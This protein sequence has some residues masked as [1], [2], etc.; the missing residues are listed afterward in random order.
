[1]NKKYDVFISYA[2]QDLVVAREIKKNLE[3]SGIRCWKAPDSIMAGE[4]WADAI[5][6]AIENTNIM[7]IVWS[8]YFSASQETSKEL[9]LASQH[10]VKIVPFRIEDLQPSGKW[11]YQLANTHWMNAHDGNIELHVDELKN[12]IINS[13]PMRKNMNDDQ[14]YNI[15][16]H[17]RRNGLAIFEQLIDTATKDGVVTDEEIKPIIRRGAKLGMTKSEVLLIVSNKL[18]TSSDKSE[19]GFLDEKTQN[20]EKNYNKKNTENSTKLADE[21]NPLKKSFSKNQ[22]GKKIQNSATRKTKKAEFPSNEP[23]MGNVKSKSI[24]AQNMNS[25]ENLANNQEIKKNKSEKSSDAIWIWGFI[26]FFAFITALLVWLGWIFLR[27]I[28]GLF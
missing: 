3:S 7:V 17:Q 14:K 19:I 26:V 20:K 8:S 21:I 28:I 1:M 2:N 4:D 22:E 15:I 24:K 27:W 6:K 13:F 9:T 16:D 25:A 11:A 23:V 18:T 12:H 10:G 5:V